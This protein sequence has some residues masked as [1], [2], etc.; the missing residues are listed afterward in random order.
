MV[1]R[2]A[3]VS[4]LANRV[5]SGLKSK[6]SKSPL[7]P[8]DPTVVTSPVPKSTR[9]RSS[10]PVMEKPMGPAQADVAATVVAAATT[11]AQSVD[12]ITR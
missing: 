1:Y 5:P 11:A 7:T 8:S 6:P 10:A 3:L 4:S 2:S 12:F 9:T